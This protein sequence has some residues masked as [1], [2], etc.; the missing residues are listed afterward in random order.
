MSLAWNWKTVCISVA[1]ISRI[2]LD[3]LAFIHS[4]LYNY[5]HAINIS[6]K[7]CTVHT[8]HLAVVCH[9]IVYLP[10]AFLYVNMFM[11]L[12]FQTFH[13]YHWENHQHRNRKTNYSHQ[14]LYAIDEFTL[15]HYTRI[16]IE[17]VEFLINFLSF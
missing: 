1:L 15:V 5:L 3:S 12:S 8:P 10:H 4:R 9:F 2:F 13:L 14:T 11:W 17:T 7:R 6:A 16:Q